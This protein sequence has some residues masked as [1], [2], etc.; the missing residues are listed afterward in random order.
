M[1]NE[2]RSLYERFLI[3]LLSAVIALVTSVSWGLEYKG[4]TTAFRLMNVK[5]REARQITLAFNYTAT[6]C[7][8][9]PSEEK[10][11]GP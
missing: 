1:S 6:H 9:P 10:K 4:R 11:R 7:A 5:A 8:A 3:P 2:P